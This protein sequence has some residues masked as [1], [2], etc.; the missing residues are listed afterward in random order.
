MR[1]RRS[2]RGRRDRRPHASRR[3]ETPVFGAME[4]SGVRHFVKE[5][6]VHFSIEPEWA[7]TP[8]GRRAVGFNV[9]LFAALE[10][11]DRT[12]PGGSKSRALAASLRKVV[13]SLLPE[14]DSAAR[15][16]V[17]PFSPA[18]YDSREVPGADEVALTLRLLHYSENYAR[19][20]DAS[21]ERC[22]RALRSRFKAV[23]L[24][25]R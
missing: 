15:I 14:C 13:E 2:A 20:V 8:G 11:G 24:P 22:L 17:E 9:R 21:E 12:L 23:S 4:Q 19:P 16:D 3:P 5:H 7:V 1:S 10:K 6:H 25:E 18:L